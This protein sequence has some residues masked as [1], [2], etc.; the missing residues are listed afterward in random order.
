MQMSSCFRCLTRGVSRHQ[1][2]L[3]LENV[4]IRSDRGVGQHFSKMSQLSYPTWDIAPL[5]LVYVYYKQQLHFYGTFAEPQNRRSKDTQTV[6]PLRLVY[7][8]YIQYLHFQGTFAEP[9]IQIHLLGFHFCGS[10]YIH[11]SQW[12]NIVKK[13]FGNH[14]NEL[15]HRLSLDSVDSLN[16]VPQT[17]LIP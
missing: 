5:R 15:F 10:A 6:D 13:S 4:S 3:N 7:V 14:R 1:N 11:Q 17:V 16:Q 2:S 8:C 12:V 9:Q